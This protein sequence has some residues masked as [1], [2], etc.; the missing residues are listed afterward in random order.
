VQTLYFFFQGVR[1]LLGHVYVRVAFRFPSL[2]GHGKRTHAEHIKKSK[3]PKHL[4]R[5]VH[6]AEQDK[7]VRTYVS[8]LSRSSH[9]SSINLG[10]IFAQSFCGT[11]CCANIVCCETRKTY[12]NHKSWNGGSKKLSHC[13]KSRRACFYFHEEGSRG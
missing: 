10:F 11:S 12:F 5:G 9:A 6:A 4:T 3:S 13:V 8:A 2:V 7:G 1:H